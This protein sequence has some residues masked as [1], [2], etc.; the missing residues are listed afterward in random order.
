[1]PN[2]PV[3]FLCFSMR[4]HVLTQGVCRRVRA[5][6]VLTNE[7]EAL[8][9]VILSPVT[10]YASPI[11]CS[12]TCPAR[13]RQRKDKRETTSRPVGMCR[14]LFA[15]NT[16]RSTKLR[17][18]TRFAGF[19][20]S[21]SRSETNSQIGRAQG[22]TL[23][24]SNGGSDLLQTRPDSTVRSCSSPVADD[25]IIAYWTCRREDS[26]QVQRHREGLELRDHIGRDVFRD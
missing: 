25:A 12:Y 2:P 16:A 5:R 23:G 1:M 9:S 4:T 19:L 14:T 8:S 11:L 15:G 3:I 20:Y 22:H 10:I 26:D 21:E 18:P 7:L 6:R 17:F 13:N 24:S